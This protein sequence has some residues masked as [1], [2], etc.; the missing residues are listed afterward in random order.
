MYDEEYSPIVA[1]TGTRAGMSQKQFDRF[2]FECKKIG[3]MSEFHHGDC[4]GADVQAATS[5]QLNKLCNEIHSWPGHIA[6]LRAGF[7]SWCR[8]SPCHCLERNRLM[9]DESDILI[10]CPREMAE[11]HR[12]GTWYTIRYAREKNVPMVIC[13]PDGTSTEE[14]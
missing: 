4:V 5:I 6:S 1:F 11:S 2:E 3:K 13:W 14:E 7:K 9:V 10:A 8:H 12:G